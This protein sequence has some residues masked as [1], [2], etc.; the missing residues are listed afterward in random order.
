M[1]QRVWQWKSG[2]VVVAEQWVGAEICGMGRR[3][4][5]DSVFEWSVPVDVDVLIVLL[6]DEQTV[7]SQRCHFF[8]P[9]RRRPASKYCT[10]MLTVEE[11]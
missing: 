7:R 9:A 8:H 1:L 10:R 11:R 2:C 5:G 4:A 6:E 3:E